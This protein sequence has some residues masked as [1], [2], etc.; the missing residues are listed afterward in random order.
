M[1]RASLALILRLCL[2]LA[3]AFAFLAFG[4][5]LGLLPEIARGPY[6]FGKATLSVLV[7]FLLHVSPTT[8]FAFAATPLVFWIVASALR[9]GPVKPVHVLA[10]VVC[11]LSGSAALVARDLMVLHATYA[12]E[13]AP[14]P[15]ITTIL[16]GVLLLVLV[17]VA[18]GPREKLRQQMARRLGSQES[19]K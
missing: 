16:D 14:I 18:I 11:F 7:A 13:P 9:A 2:A 8:W 3:V 4:L 17:G 19:E 10:A 12:V 1:M 6:G 15:P 5:C